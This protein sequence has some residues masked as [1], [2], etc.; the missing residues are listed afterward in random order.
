M[1]FSQMC[2]TWLISKNQVEFMLTSTVYVNSDG[3]LN[4]NRY[5]YTEMGWPFLYDLGQT[6]Y[7]YELKRDRQHKPD[8]SKF[9]IQYEKRDPA[10]TRPA[11]KD[12]AN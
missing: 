5:E 9:R 7:Q 12:V 2:H 3:I 4:D 10:D 1:V 11:L 6:V 8:L